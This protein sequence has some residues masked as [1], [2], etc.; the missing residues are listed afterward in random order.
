MQAGRFGCCRAKDGPHGDKDR[1][2]LSLF[3]LLIFRPV[4]WQIRA[5]YACAPLGMLL[6]PFSFLSPCSGQ[7]RRVACAP[8]ASA[9]VHDRRGLSTLA[10]RVHC[11]GTTLPRALNV[12]PFVTSHNDRRMLLP[13]AR[14]TMVIIWR[15][16]AGGGHRAW[17]KRRDGPARAPPD[18]SRPD[19][20]SS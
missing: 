11:F 3:D 18:E 4:T 10:T 1:H 15:K 13:G 6:F 19:L 8:P 2:Q 17:N 14:V 9:E 7:W 5:D 20:G 12:R 16:D